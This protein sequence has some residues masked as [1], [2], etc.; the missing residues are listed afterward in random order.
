MIFFNPWK[1]KS[2]ANK[3]FD[4]KSFLL[5]LAEFWII[6]LLFVFL[7]YQVIIQKKNRLFRLKWDVLYTLYCAIEGIDQSEERSILP[8]SKTANHSAVFSRS[9]DQLLQSKIWRKMLWKITRWRFDT[10]SSVKMAICS[11]TTP[12]FFIQC[13]YLV[14]CYQI[15]LFF[16]TKMALFDSKLYFPNSWLRYIPAAIK[17][18]NE[19][20]KS[21]QIMTDFDVSFSSKLF[22]V[23]WYKLDCRE[24]QNSNWFTIQDL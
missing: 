17:L 4:T 8:L 22:F 6:I 10:K 16:D 24:N 18:N 20:K 2:K 12:S 15:W 21:R 3:P 23:V 5:F 7:C 1:K 9:R 11:Y 13:R 14:Q 19:G